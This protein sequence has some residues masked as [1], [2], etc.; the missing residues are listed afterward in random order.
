MNSTYKQNTKITRGHME[1]NSRKPKEWVGI[2]NE[3][4]CKFVSVHV[5]VLLH[6]GHACLSYLLCF[7][8]ILLCFALPCLLYLA[9]TPHCFALSCMLCLLWPWPCLQCLWPCL[10][11][12]KVLHKLYIWNWTPKTYINLANCISNILAIFYQHTQV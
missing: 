9:F 11:C 5:H 6:R 1:A 3:P 12:L 10:L 2:V 7:A 4:S 8:P